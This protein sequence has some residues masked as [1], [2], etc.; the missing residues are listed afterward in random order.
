[1]G[2]KN[3][4]FFKS[5]L[6]QYLLLE[7][8]MRVQF[9][10]QIEDLKDMLSRVNGINFFQEWQELFGKISKEWQTSDINTP[11]FELEGVY[12]DRLA[13]YIDFIAMFFLYNGSED[14]NEYLNNVDEFFKQ[15]KRE[16]GENDII[17]QFKS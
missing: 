12:M 2:T 1:L 17:K 3:I 14:D 13:F 15:H 9:F 7:S 8:D 6:N 11:F 16:R 4:L 5:E 10:T